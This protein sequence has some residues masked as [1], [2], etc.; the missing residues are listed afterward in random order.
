ML[1]I[2]SDWIIKVYKSIYFPQDVFSDLE[3]INDATQQIVDSNLFEAITATILTL[4]ISMM[5][6]YFFMDLAEKSASNILSIQQLFLAF[7]K[8]IFVAL[9]M[10]YSQELISGMMKFGT[11]LADTITGINSSGEFCWFDV[12]SAY[13]VEGEGTI[14]VGNEEAMKHCLNDLPILNQVTFVVKLIPPYLIAFATE[15]IFYI[16]LISRSVELSVRSLFCPLAVA[17]AFGDTRRSS[18]IRYLKKIFALILQ[19]V[20][21]VA[22]VLALNEVIKGVSSELSDPMEVFQTKPAFKGSVGYFVGFAVGEIGDAVAGAIE[23]WQWSLIEGGG[24]LKLLENVIGAAVGFVGG[25]LGGLL[26]NL[27][28][29]TITAVDPDA[30]GEFLASLLGGSNYWMFIALSVAKAY[31]LIKSQSL[32]NDIVGTS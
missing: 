6:I 20:V 19:L 25:A 28:P 13:E 18:A 7:L 27:S 16:I 9:L 31:L 23:G 3:K 1:S 30:V 8:L 5:L 21:A 2:F 26:P 29:I 15:I 24:V 17:D 22:I 32:A 14:I 11:A 12:A 4:G 10:S